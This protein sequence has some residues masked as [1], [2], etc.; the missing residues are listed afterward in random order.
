M[1]NSKNKALVFDIINHR[2]KKAYDKL[3]PQEQEVVDALVAAEIE[4]KAFLENF[5]A[6]ARDSAKKGSKIFEQNLDESDLTSDI[7]K[8]AKNIFSKVIVKRIDE[9]TAQSLKDLKEGKGVLYNAMLSER[10]I[11][12]LDAIQDFKSKVD[13]I[14]P[15]PSDQIL[16]YAAPALLGLANIYAPGIAIVLKTTGIIDKVAKFL[17]TGNLKTTIDNLRNGLEKVNTDKELG[18]IAKTSELSRKIGV[19][20]S[21]LSKLGFDSNVLDAVNKE[22][23]AIPEAKKLMQSLCHYAD[24]VLVKNEKDIDTRLATIKQSTINVLEKIGIP[25]DVLTGVMKQIDKNFAE[26]KKSLGSILD[27]TTKLFDKIQ[28][29]T[30]GANSILGCLKNVTAIAQSVMSEKGSQMVKTMLGAVVKEAETLIKSNVRE[31]MVQAINPKVMNCMKALGAGHVALIGLKK[32][33]NVQ[34]AKEVGRSR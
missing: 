22:V 19:P 21:I 25:K 14:L 12:I 17:E 28:V 34:Q 23:Q 18:N 10:V 11:D 30:D 29:Q 9:V 13:E 26:V 1:K 6:A 32:I 33:A 27:P 15:I 3:S 4:A 16:K 5:P 24:E 31:I 20:F 2:L 8:Q 7:K